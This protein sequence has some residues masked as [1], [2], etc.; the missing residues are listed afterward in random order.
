MFSNAGLQNLL[1]AK[2]VL[3]GK[4]P[5]LLSLSGRLEGFQFTQFSLICFH[6]GWLALQ[7]KTA[8]FVQ[9]LQQRGDAVSSSD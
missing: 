2:S 3:N 1:L 4:Q 6:T 9:N 8:K 7:H 5:S